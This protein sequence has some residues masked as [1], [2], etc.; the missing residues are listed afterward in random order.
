M[1]EKT[2][3]Q[4]E[5][6]RREISGETERTFSISQKEKECFGISGDQ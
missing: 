3:T 6:K 4:K 1:A 2:K 5:M